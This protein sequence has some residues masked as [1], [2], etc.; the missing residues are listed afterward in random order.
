VTDL[1]KINECCLGNEV[2]GKHIQR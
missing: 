2:T 1:R